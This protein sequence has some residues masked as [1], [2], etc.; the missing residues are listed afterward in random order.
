[1]HP[2]LSP[3]IAQL[4]SR[5]PFALRGDTTADVA[6]VGAGIAGVSTAASIL[7]E[8]N[9]SVVLVD[10]RRIAHGATGHNAGHLVADF[11]RPFGELVRDFGLAPAV[12]A[13]AEI[14][15]GWD[16]IHDFSSAFSLKT[17][18]YQ[19]QGFLGFTTPERIRLHL[20]ETKLRA[21]HGLEREALLIAVGSE[22]ESA[23]APSDEP[24]VVRMPHHMIL[25]LLRTD[26]SSFIAAATSGR[27]CMNSALFCEEL[28]GSLLA[29]YGDRLC[30][31]EH[32]P[33]RA[34]TLGARATL[35]TDGPTIT[36]DRVVL[37]TNGFENVHIEN[38]DGPPIDRSFHS[39]VQGIIGYMGGYLEDGEESPV[40][41]AYF[42]EQKTHLDPYIYL[43]R[44]PYDHN[45]TLL[46]LGGPE[47]IFPDSATYDPLTPFPSDV[48]EEIDRAFAGIYRKDDEAAPRKSF[49]WHGIMGY[50]PSGVRCVG[51]DPRNGRLF[52]NLGCNGIGILPA[53]AGSR[54]I[55][56]LLNGIDLPTSLFDPAVQMDSARL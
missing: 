15:S 56:H 5:R 4:T 48:E 23:I 25:R 51:K 16:I 33:V 55:A 6:I 30:V 10:A 22:A 40:A 13:L 9:C 42:R 53:I 43:T 14:E 21:Q 1:M 46:C 47:R 31:A 17:R 38:E 20:E 12:R 52:Y 36:A 34:I 54:R 3:W 11:E 7:R 27:G 39:L 18:L 26:D 2:I 29:R 37:C 24:H 8:T 45:R 41:I 19:C 32:L 28:T 49:L 44:R 35:K 50:T